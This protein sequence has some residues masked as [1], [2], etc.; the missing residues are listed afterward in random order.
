MLVRRWIVGII[1]VLAVAA[2]S[3][4]EAVPFAVVVEPPEVT[5]IIADGSGPDNLIINA[6]GIHIASVDPR[7]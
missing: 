1:A 3:G 6:T 4:D 2:C 5:G 7:K